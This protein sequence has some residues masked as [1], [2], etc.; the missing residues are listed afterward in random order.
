MAVVNSLN[1]PNARHKHTTNTNRLVREEVLEKANT[2]VV[3]RDVVERTKDV[4]VVVVTGDVGLVGV[5]GNKNVGMSRALV[6][7]TSSSDMMRTAVKE[8][9]R[10]FPFYYA[11]R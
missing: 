8:T 10:T 11:F 6:L 7:A 5:H 1:R 9:A 2:L 3:P 4:R